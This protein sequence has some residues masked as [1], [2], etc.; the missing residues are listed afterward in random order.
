[1]PKYMLTMSAKKNGVILT[2]SYDFEAKSHFSEDIL[3]RDFQ[4][5]N[6]GYKDIRVISYIEIAPDLRMKPIIDN[7]SMLTRLAYA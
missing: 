7:S 4:E 5:Y 2:T 3:I 1:M 6:P